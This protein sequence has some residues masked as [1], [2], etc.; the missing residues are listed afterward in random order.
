MIAERND[1]LSAITSVSI[2]LF[3]YLFICGI[4]ICGFEPTDQTLCN[5]R[6]L[7]AW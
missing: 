6:G 2:N 3:V 4:G 7:D 1:D 5:D